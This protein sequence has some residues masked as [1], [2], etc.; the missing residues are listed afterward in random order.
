MVRTNI[1]AHRG[2]KGT[3]PENTLIAFKNALDLGVDG[4][5]FDVHL[6]KD[7][8]L[9]IIHDET[10]DRTTDGTGYI[11][12]MT[13]M[14]I[15][16]LDAG[17]KFSEEFKGERIP[18]LQEV[19]ELAR[20]YPH[21]IL[22]IE[23]KTDYIQYEGIEE[24]IIQTVNEMNV[25]NSI[26]FSS[27]NHYSLVKV[28][29]IN[30]D[31]DTAILFFEGLYEPWNYAKGIGA[32]ALHI[33]EPIAFSPMVEMAQEVDFPVRVFTVNKEEHMVNLISRGVDAIMTDFPKKAMEI[34]EQLL[35]SK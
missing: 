14:E 11:K 35:A 1:Y 4:L 28:K 3:H 17:L 29:E 8:E 32:S 2:S 26:V 13:L 19:L 15:K 24:K 16:T 5:E 34:R 7:G 12:D 6:T 25:K 18:T 23:I 21:V 33:Y 27:F 31:L 30:K 10:V 9:V 22:N 20:K